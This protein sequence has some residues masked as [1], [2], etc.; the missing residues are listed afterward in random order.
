MVKSCCA[1]SA[2]H[3]LE[4]AATARQK[5]SGGHTG[6]SRCTGGISRVSRRAKMPI[7]RIAPS[8]P[9]VISADKL[10]FVQ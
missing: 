10:Q 2:D 4:T 1:F 8:H 5:C 9:P 6:A 7:R 3:S